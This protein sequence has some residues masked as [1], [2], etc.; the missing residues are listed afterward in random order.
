ML[1]EEVLGL[2]EFEPPGPQLPVLTL[3]AL[4]PPV[5]PSLTRVTSSQKSLRVMC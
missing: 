4:V 1:E 3:E 2:V 5:V